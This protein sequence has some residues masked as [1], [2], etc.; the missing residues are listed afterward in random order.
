MKEVPTFNDIDFKD[1]DSQFVKD[2]GVPA[3]NFI[4]FLKFHLTEEEAINES[5]RLISVMPDELKQVL[6]I[7]KL[8]GTFNIEERILL[9][10]MRYP[11]RKRWQ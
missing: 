3:F 2:W 7:R 9:Q 4:D 10:K 5:I 6:W 8:A 1:K 11:S